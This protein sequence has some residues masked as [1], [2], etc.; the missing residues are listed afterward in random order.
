MSR[1]RSSPTGRPRAGRLVATV[2]LAGMTLLAAGCSDDPEVRD[3]NGAVVEAGEWSVFDLSFGDCLMPKEKLVDDVEK[4]P[5]VPC[6]Q[7]HTQEVFGTITHPA[8]A[9]PGA[10]ELQTFAQAGCVAELQTVADVSP[11]DGYYVSYLLP[12]FDSWNAKDDRG[13]VCVLV[14]PTEG[15]RTGS[16]LLD[17]RTKSGAASSGA[18]AGAVPT[19][20]VPTTAAGSA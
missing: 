2:A 20:A 4:I 10:A 1:P 12:S 5:V 19:S 13:I 3:A 9:Y 17:A 6:E 15:P 11:A 8:D 18:P 7:P 14:F 16:A